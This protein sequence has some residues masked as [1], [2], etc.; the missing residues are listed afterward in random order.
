LI[1]DPVPTVEEFEEL[2]AA[3]SGVDLERTSAG[4]IVVHAPA[5]SGHSAQNA[6]ITYQLVN[7]WEN[8][9]RGM[10]CDSS[11]GVVFPDTSSRSPDAAYITGEQAQTIAEE[12]SDRF[13]R[14]IPAF[15]IELRSQSDS[16]VKAKEKMERWIAAGAQLAWLVDPYSRSV[17][18]YEAGKTPRVESGNAVVGTGPVDGFV[19]DLSK[20]W[21]LSRN[22]GKR[23]LR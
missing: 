9:G 12:D 6:F 17:F 20:V 15:I 14:F 8:H 13:L 7:W 5:G 2:C 21:L 10:V 11:L 18:I 16:L 1:L 23:P 22:Q 4:E 19:L 3:N